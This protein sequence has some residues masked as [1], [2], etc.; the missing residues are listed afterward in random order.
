[1]MSKQLW[2]RL[3]AL[4]AAAMLVACGGD[5][6]AGVGS[7]GTGGGP[8]SSITGG[9]IT[10]FGSVIVD[11]TTWDDRNA[12]IDTEND[13]RQAASSAELALGKR[14]E[15]TSTTAGVAQRI[16]VEATVAGR[17]TDAPAGTPLQFKVAGQTVRQ[18]TNPAAGPITVLEGYTAFSQIAVNDI[19]EVH[20]T[21]VFDSTANRYVIQA[22]RVEKLAE[23]PSGMQRIAGIVEAYNTSTAPPTFR[24]GELTV[25][26][27]DTTT[28]VPANRAIANGQSVVVFSNKQITAGPRLSADVIRIKDRTPSSGNARVELS[29]TTS[30]FNATSPNGVTFEINGTPVDARNARVTPANQ[31]LANDLYVIVRGTYTTNG[32]LVAEDVRIRNGGTAAVEIELKGNVTDYVSIANFRVRNVQINGTGATLS[33]CGSGLANGV[34]VEIKGRIDA[35]TGQARAT[36]IECKNPPGN[37]TITLV[38][39][40]SAV[41]TATRQFTLTPSGAPARTVEWTTTTNFVGQLNT[42]NLSGQNVEVDGYV[43]G[44][45]VIATKIKRRN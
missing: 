25:A 13:P 21:P 1:M 33:N 5:E 26:V 8:T 11:G 45:V 39:I 23:L 31:T 15:I 30:K 43:S 40:T 6:V 18:N 34:F 29:G 42:T 7:G 16:R 4:A 9:G 28:V 3:A 37:A 32:V 12:V 10:G 41:N 14:V 19:V 22:S 38:G 44:Q 2:A 27:E 24:L 20:G 17:V 36:E 35:A